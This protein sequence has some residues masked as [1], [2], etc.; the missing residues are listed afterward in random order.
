MVIPFILRFQEKCTEVDLSQ[1][2][3]GTKSQTFTRAEQSDLDFEH[4]SYEVFKKQELQAGT[5]S[6]TAIRAEQSDKDRAFSSFGLIPTESVLLS[7]TQTHTR[8]RA[9]EAD[10]YSNG[11][12]NR[13]IPIWSLS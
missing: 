1:T 9:E 3:S 2:T 4:W 11:Q 13:A 8:I 12:Q 6:G 10:E 7:G 5:M